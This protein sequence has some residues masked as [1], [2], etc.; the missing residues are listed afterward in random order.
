MASGI[1]FNT[2]TYA[3]STW[4][5]FDAIAKCDATGFPVFH[6]DL[7]KQMVWSGNSLIWN[8]FLVHKDFNYKP[9][10]FTNIPPVLGDPEPVL[11]ARPFPFPWAN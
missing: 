5:N 7:R 2:S 10:P 4:D 9:N 8:G 6:K 1:N 11:N 3:Q